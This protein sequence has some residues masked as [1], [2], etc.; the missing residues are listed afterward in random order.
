MLCWVADHVDSVVELCQRFSCH[1]ADSLPSTSH[2]NSLTLL[3]TE[4][5]PPDDLTSS[6]HSLDLDTDFE[7]NIVDVGQ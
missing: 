5:Q 3:D 2:Y 7:V 4:L 1:S 6:E